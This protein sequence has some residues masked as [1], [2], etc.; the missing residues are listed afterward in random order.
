M[1]K[2][3]VVQNRFIELRAVKS[4]FAVI[5]S[6]CIVCPDFKISQIWYLQCFSLV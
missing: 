5:V 4:N 6:T 3:C 2:S 1:N